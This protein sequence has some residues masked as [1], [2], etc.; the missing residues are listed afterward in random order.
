M[1]AELPQLVA[2]QMKKRGMSWTKRGGNRMAR[3]INLRNQGKLHSRVNYRSQQ[4]VS[5][6]RKAKPN[7]DLT[8]DKYGKQNHAAWL[9]GELPALSGPHCNRLWAQV[10]DA[11]AH[12]TGIIV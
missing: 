11:I 6:S 7:I 1:Q 5:R 9:E 4:T 3:L 8:V 12:S 10:L 2:T